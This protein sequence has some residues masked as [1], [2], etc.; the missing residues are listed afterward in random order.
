MIWPSW[1]QLQPLPS[2]TI[3]MSVGS[4]GG[5]HRAHA[6]RYAEVLAHQGIRL[7]LRKSAGLDENYQRLN[8]LSSEIDLALVQ[9][10]IGDTRD[11]QPRRTCICLI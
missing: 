11:S 2:K 3:V 5:S 1:A 8:D 7:E 6:L 9:S 4:D 10:G